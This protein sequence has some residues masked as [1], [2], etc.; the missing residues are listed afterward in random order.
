MDK[1]I[2]FGSAHLIAVGLGIFISFLFITLGFFIRKD[3]LAKFLAVIALGVKITELVY[4]HHVFGEEI[5]GL[6]PFHLCNLTLI[7]AII[8][9][10]CS[11]RIVFQPLYFW[12]IGAIFAIITPEISLGFKDFASISFFITHFFII[13][14]VAYGIIHFNFKVTKLGAFSSFI[15]LNLI[16]LG[17]YF[18]NNKLGTNYLYV[19]RPPSSASPVDFFGPWP[20]YIFSVE[21]IYIALSFI[22]YLPFRE[23]KT[24]Y[25]R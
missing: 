24:R 3:S 25:I 20:Y 11:S 4:R 16:A 9:M 8:M 5:I 19:N 7:L 2:L 1:F 17:L 18:L 10:L 15:F 13:F 14:S 22:L 21:G 6:L 23:K 12:S